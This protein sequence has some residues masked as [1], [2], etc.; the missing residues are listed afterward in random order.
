MGRSDIRKNFDIGTT[1]YNA[2]VNRSDKPAFHRRELRE[3]IQVI[4][5]KKYQATLLN[6]L[7]EVYELYVPYEEKAG[8]YWDANTNIAIAIGDCKVGELLYHMLAPKDKDGNLLQDKDGSLL[9]PEAAIGSIS[10]KQYSTITH[11]IRTGKQTARDLPPVA[12]IANGYTISEYAKIRLAWVLTSPDLGYDELEQIVHKTRG[13]KVDY[14]SIAILASDSSYS[15][16][17]LKT[18]DENYIKRYLPRM[19]QKEGLHLPVLTDE[20]TL[21]YE[22]LDPSKAILCARGPRDQ[23]QSQKKR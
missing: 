15:R 4:F 18:V 11:N 21:V 6:Y 14:F 5:P 1:P 19:V 8:S 10:I 23:K 7:E 2:A 13:G 9:L 20:G 17:R 16:K 3:A 12:I 22:P